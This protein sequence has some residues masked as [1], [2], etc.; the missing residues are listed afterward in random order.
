MNGFFI[1]LIV[2]LSLL[3][4]SQIFS[5]TCKNSL[6]QKMKQEINYQPEETI[7]NCL[8]AELDGLTPREGV[9]Y[10]SRPEGKDVKNFSV[11][12]FSLKKNKIRLM[13]RLET[14]SE[15]LLPGYIRIVD[16]D[17]NQREEIVIIGNTD[18]TRS[19]E[20]FIFEWANGHLNDRVYGESPGIAYFFSQPGNQKMQIIA[21]QPD[22]QVVTLVRKGI[23]Y[24]S[25]KQQPSHLSSHLSNIFANHR[26]DRPY[27]DLD[28][29]IKALKDKTRFDPSILPKIKNSFQ[30]AKAKNRASY[31]KMSGLVASPQAKKLLKNSLFDTS[32]PPFIR[33]AAFEGLFLHS[34]QQPPPKSYFRQYLQSGGSEPDF[35][36][37]AI[38]TMIRH[39]DAQ[40]TASI[41]LNYFQSSASLEN[42]KIVLYRGIA[43]IRRHLS[44]YLLQTA[45]QPGD[46]TLRTIAAFHLELTRPKKTSYSAQ[47]LKHG[48]E[49]DLPAVRD[50]TTLFVGR[51]KD[52]QYIPQLMKNL[53]NTDSAISRRKTIL[54][55]DQLQAYRYAKLYYSILKKTS[56]RRLR[57]ALHKILAQTDHQKILLYSLKNVRTSR[58]AQF[59]YLRARQEKTARMDLVFRYLIQKRSS[60]KL[61]RKCILALGFFTT[62]KNKQFLQNLLLKKLSDPLKIAA[63]QALDH[64]KGQIALSYW[65]K[66]LNQKPSPELA[67]EIKTILARSGNRQAIS[68]LL[69]DLH[70][71]STLQALTAARPTRQTI[72]TLQQEQEKI[73]QALQKNPDCFDCNYRKYLVARALFALDPQ[74][75]GQ[76]AVKN[77]FK[78]NQYLTELVYFIASQKSQPVSFLRKFRNHPD[79]SVRV[80]I[81]HALANRN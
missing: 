31:L 3:Q 6:I 58:E 41:L 46:R 28:F 29:A 69:S 65:Q 77:Q 20:I 68:Y 10:L 52:T 34:S 11:L 50:A 42:K 67:T 24:Y 8:M 59:Y 13:Q 15:Y 55:L 64:S 47:L 35:L 12:V 40:K 21:V 45:V 54:A 33:A 60:E 14:H 5:E 9:L 2:F 26:P 1:F 18:G 56:D 70:K 38:Q 66:I 48:L 72:L 17:Q 75:L 78:S 25:Q 62:N 76:T 32:Q 36:Q 37:P 49:S 7:E 22:Y 57:L 16:L 53:Q 23:Y 51:L 27:P 63:I 71:N 4:T 44:H 73:Q 43:P 79:R 30:Q 61:R 19:R 81:S 39:T 74:N 80:A